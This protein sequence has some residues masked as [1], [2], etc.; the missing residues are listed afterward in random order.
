MLLTTYVPYIFCLGSLGEYDL[1]PFWELYLTALHELV[2]PV[3]IQEG[4]G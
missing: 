4:V 3:M 1:G 2:V